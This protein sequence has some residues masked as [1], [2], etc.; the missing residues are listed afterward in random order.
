LSRGYPVNKA[1]PALIGVCIGADRFDTA[2]YYARARLL[3]EPGDWSL[4]YLVA[5]L[6]VSAGQDHQ[7]VVEIHRLIDE[8]PGRP[9]PHYLLAVVARDTLGNRRLA[10]ESFGTYLSLAPGGS[11]VPEARAFLKEDRRS[12]DQKRMTR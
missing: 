8:Q 2:L 1:F 4:R 10:V 5:T 11:H 6:L 7:A 3:K 12:P 9:E